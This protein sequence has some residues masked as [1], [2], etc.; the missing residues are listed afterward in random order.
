V[1]V[2]TP[3]LEETWGKIT[4]SHILNFLKVKWLVRP[5]SRPD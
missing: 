3:C 5:T 1:L 4:K 2:S